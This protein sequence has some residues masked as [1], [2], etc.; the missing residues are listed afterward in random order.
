MCAGHGLHLCDKEQV[1]L[2]RREG[3][4]LDVFVEMGELLTART[5]RVHLP[6]L[7]TATFA[8]EEGD[9]RPSLDPDHVALR[10]RG[11]RDLLV[12]GAICVHHEDLPVALVLWHAV[13]AHRVSDLFTVG[14]DLVIADAPESPQR[15]RRHSSILDLNVGLANQFT[16]RLISLLRSG[17]CAQ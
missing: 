1:T 10:F 12:A 16:C 17:T 7:A 14:G 15:F 6:H 11:V 9:L 8:T 4:P 3:E 2:I 5:I 13:I